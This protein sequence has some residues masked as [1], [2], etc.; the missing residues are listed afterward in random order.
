[1]DVQQER[2]FDDYVRAR[3][4][5]LMK[6]SFFLLGDWH[7]AEDVSQAAL[8][9]LYRAWPRIARYES[10][11]AYA[12]RVVVNEANRWWRRPS[13]RE[14]PRAELADAALPSDTTLEMRDELWRL[15]LSL[16]RRQRAVLVL[17][18]LEEL[19]EQE[20]ATALGCTTG[21][22]KSSTSK[23][24]ARLHTAVMSQLGGVQ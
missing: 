2:D 4:P 18:Y 19:S 7:L 14:L 23:A 13:A 12:R 11:D 15:L 17:R 8:V 5:A 24:L 1:V 21:T 16:P 6:L 10:L 9:R 3:G 20:T 22:V